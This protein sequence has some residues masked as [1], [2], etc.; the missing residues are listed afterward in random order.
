MKKEIYTEISLYG[1]LRNFGKKK[2]RTSKRTDSKG[3][4]E[5]RS[6][7]RFKRIS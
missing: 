5:L 1:E 2:I 6:Q 4:Q 3:L 7:K